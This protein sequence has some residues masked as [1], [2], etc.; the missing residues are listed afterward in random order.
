MGPWKKHLPVTVGHKNETLPEILVDVL[1]AC[2]GGFRT[3]SA[4]LHNSRSVISAQL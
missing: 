3:K 1:I 4:P 2:G